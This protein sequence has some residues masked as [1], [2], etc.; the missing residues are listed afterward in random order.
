MQL[1]RDLY[2]FLGNTEGG[3]FKTGDN[4]I[5]EMDAEG[6]QHVRFMPVAAWETPDAKEIV[7]PLILDMMFI[8]D[9]FAETKVSLFFYVYASYCGNEYLQS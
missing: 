2:K 3:T 7:D 8:L 4:I 6:N 9:F 1:H 5:R